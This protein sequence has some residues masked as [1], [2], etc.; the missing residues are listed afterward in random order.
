[1]RKYSN[2]ATSMNLKIGHLE[3]AK[4]LNEHTAAMHPLFIG[5]QFQ[6]II[7]ATQ[8]LI[9]ESL[10]QPISVKYCYLLLNKDSRLSTINALHPKHEIDIDLNPDLDEIDGLRHC[11]IS[12][13][14]YNAKRPHHNHN[15]A[16]V[17]GTPQMEESKQHILCGNSE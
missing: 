1:M 11:E 6:N 7:F 3:A 16:E 4:V 9:C 12:H 10:T 17:W 13:H 15:N 5:K 8:I 2:E 14:Q